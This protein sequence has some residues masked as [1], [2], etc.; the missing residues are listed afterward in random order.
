MDILSTIFLGHPIQDWLAAVGVGSGLLAIVKILQ[1]YLVKRFRRLDGHRDDNYY[2]LTATLLQRLS[3]PL[4]VVFSL[5]VGSRFL[6]LGSAIEKWL[7]A[8]AVIAIILQTARWGNTLVD[9]ALVRY[10]MKT[11]GAE[12]ERMTTLRAVGFVC[13]LAIVALAVLLALDNIPG[14][15]ITALVASLGIGG[16]AVA[17]AVQ[18]VLADLFASLS[19]VLD[20][21]FVIGDFIIVDNH[22]GSVEYIGLKTT[23]LRS[24]SGEQLIFSNSDLLKS[25]I[26][27]YKRM[28]ER[29]VVFSIS[30]V[31]QTQRSKLRKIPAEIKRIVE[32]LEQVR[33]DRAHFQGFGESGLNFEVVYYVLSSDYTVYMDIQQEI[34]LA[35]FQYFEKEGVAFAFPTRSLYLHQSDTPPAAAV[36]SRT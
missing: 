33:F 11:D 32:S 23:R 24:L 29:R 36:S 17:M 3:F 5:F 2:G 12:G 19:I 15:E 16:I 10:Q 22:L 6:D 20:K 14:V 9:F 30:V 18:N 13:R 26:K 25:R 7:S 8:I 35:I 21:P 28:E 1:S 31:Y 4:A 27:N 34:N